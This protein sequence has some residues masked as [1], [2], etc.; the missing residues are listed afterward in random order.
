MTMIQIAADEPV[1]QVMLS[2]IE[3]T[4]NTAKPRLYMRTRPYMSPTR[5]RLTTSTLVT[6]RNPIRI[7]RKYDVLP[8]ASGFILMPRKMSGRAIIRIELLIVAIR[9]P[10]VVLD[11]AIHLY[12]EELEG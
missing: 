11:S 7:Q 2:R 1:I 5:P 12:D 8:G 3:K 4:V 9:T 10:I 6:S